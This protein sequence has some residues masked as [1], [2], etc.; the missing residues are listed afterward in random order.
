MNPVNKSQLCRELKLPT[1]V[2]TYLIHSKVLI[3]KQRGN[4]VIFTKKSV[5]DFKALFQRDNYLTVGE[6]KE[7][8]TKKKYY[9]QFNP[10]MKLVI[11]KFDF[12]VTVK[13]LIDMN[14]LQ[15]IS[16]GST[17]YITKKSANKTLKWLQ[18]LDEELN[19]MPTTDQLMPIK[20][21][22]SKFGKKP[23]KFKKPKGD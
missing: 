19:P 23:I 16:F 10:Q 18:G 20:K 15:S 7:L 1:Y 17:V 21:K 3:T 11:N 12:S 6:L 2:I 9:D 14:K 8:L 5:E 4:S 13:N 22:R